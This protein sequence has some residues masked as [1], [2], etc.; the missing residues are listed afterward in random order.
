MSH[1]G[2]LWIALV[3]TFVTYP[4]IASAATYTVTDLGTLGGTRSYAAGYQRARRHRR[5]VNARR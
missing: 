1:I 4:P 5:L 2:T 3:A